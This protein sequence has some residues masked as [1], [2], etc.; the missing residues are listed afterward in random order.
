[1]PIFPDQIGSAAGSRCRVEGLFRG[2]A[3]LFDQGRRS[4]CEFKYCAG[5]DFRQ[6][7]DRAQLSVHCLATDTGVLDDFLCLFELLLDPVEDTAKLL[8]FGF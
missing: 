5:L 3:R 4:E 1:M 7:F 8:E 6:N 2:L